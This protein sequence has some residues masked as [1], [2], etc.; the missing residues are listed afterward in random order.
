MK[1]SKTVIGVVLLVAILL[2]AVGYAAIQNVA[3]EIKGNAAATAKQEN[4]TV[5]FTGTPTTDNSGVPGAVVTADKVD[6]THA[7]INVSGLT[8]NLDTVSATYE[9]TNTSADLAAVLSEV[10]TVGGTNKDY[11]SVTTD[12]KEVNLAAGAKT[13]VTVTVQ[14]V[15]TPIDL[16]PTATITVA[17]DAA[18]VQPDSI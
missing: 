4:F 1:N 3:L 7:S 18:P 9:I 12:I 8:A 17:I 14:L 15:R 2:V 13:A 16:D 6:K 11:F 10:T 5:E